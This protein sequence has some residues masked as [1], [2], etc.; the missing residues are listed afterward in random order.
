MELHAV[1][2]P[3]HVVNRCIHQSQQSH[4]CLT[5]ILYYRHAKILVSSGIGSITELK[6]KLPLDSRALVLLQFVGNLR[7]RDSN[8]AIVARC[9]GMFSA[10]VEY[11]QRRT[12]SYV[13]FAETAL[14]NIAREASENMQCL[15]GPLCT[16]RTPLYFA[17]YL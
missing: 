11:M 16:R 2:M 10:L 5:C 4:V 7:P 6:L 14:R 9:A 12:P 15:Q 13:R 3:V 8:K 17:Y 1:G